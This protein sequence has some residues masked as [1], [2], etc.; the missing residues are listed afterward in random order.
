MQDFSTDTIMIRMNTDKI[1]AIISYR[2]L[3]DTDARE[4]CA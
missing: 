2:K 4:A 3:V 1:D